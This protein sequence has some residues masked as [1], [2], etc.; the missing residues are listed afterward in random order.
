MIHG[1]R[2][3]VK[4]RKGKRVRNLDKDRV[5]SETKRD[6]TRKTISEVSKKSKNSMKSGTISC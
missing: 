2:G 4:G 1:I 3:R 6:A 5:D